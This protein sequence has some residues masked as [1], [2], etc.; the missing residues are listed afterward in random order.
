MFLSETIRLRAIKFYLTLGVTSFT[1]DYIGKTL[2]FSLYV[3]M[4]PRV[5]HIA[6]S[7]RPVPR[8]PKL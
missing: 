8:V 3:A 1:W 4:R 2:E 5:L 7:S 6:L